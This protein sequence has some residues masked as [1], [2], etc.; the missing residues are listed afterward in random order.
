MLADP[1]YTGDES[2]LV[3]R[4]CM[5]MA[6]EALKAGYDAIL[7]GTFLKDEY[8]DEAIR[9]LA[10]HYSSYLVVYIAC[11]LKTVYKRNA[12]RKD[13]VPKRSLLRMYEI[14][15]EPTS[16]LRIEGSRTKPREAAEAVLLQVR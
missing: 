11:D 2:K 12:S 1:K 15:E 10:G 3:Y 8:R 7:D 5:L 9:R 4:A 6:R 14:L 16:A 13:R